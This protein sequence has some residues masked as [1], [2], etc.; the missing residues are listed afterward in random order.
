MKKRDVK[1][2]ET[3][4]VKVSGNLAAVRILCESPYGVG[5]SAQGN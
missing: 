3:Y 2:G 4:L 5:E 1:I